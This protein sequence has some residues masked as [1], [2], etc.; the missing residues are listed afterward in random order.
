MFE[1]GAATPVRVL[2]SGCVFNDIMFHY[3]IFKKD[4]NIY[5]ES[6]FYLFYLSKSQALVISIEA[7]ALSEGLADQTA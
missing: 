1:C 4:S 6:F 7:F 3:S 5:F 2:G